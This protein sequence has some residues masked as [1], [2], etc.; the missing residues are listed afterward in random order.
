M[1]KRSETTIGPVAV[2][3]QTITL[4]ARTRSFRLGGRGFGA[5]G[6]RAR[7]THVEILDADGRHHVVRIRDFEGALMAGIAI[8]GTGYIL[9]VHALRKAR[10]R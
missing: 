1:V 7:P 9:A 5:L 6:M 4:V 10:S 3:G 8:A 2:D